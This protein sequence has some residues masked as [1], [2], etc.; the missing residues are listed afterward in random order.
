MPEIKTHDTRHLEPWV[1]WVANEDCVT[2]EVWV[3]RH[4]P[5]RLR[6]ELDPIFAGIGFVWQH[7]TLL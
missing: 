4:V 1:Y 2:T 3:G 5:E 7:Q 6:G